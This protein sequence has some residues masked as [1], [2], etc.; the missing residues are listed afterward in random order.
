MNHVIQ[1]K[2]EIHR[3]YDR[4]ILLA[5]RITLQAPE[6]QHQGAA[7]QIVEEVLG[8]IDHSELHPVVQQGVN[9]VPYWC[10]VEGLGDIVHPEPEG[11][12]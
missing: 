2:V 10:C 6:L 5:L 4:Q 7:L 12:V 3:E 8:G 11:G 9:I 1:M